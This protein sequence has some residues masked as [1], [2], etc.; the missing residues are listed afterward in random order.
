MNTTAI[1][2]ITS[3]LHDKVSVEGLSDAFLK[4]L[5]PDGGFEFRGADFSDFGTCPLNLIYI[6]TGGAEGIFQ[7]L[8]PGILKAGTGK[9]YLLTSGKNNS[10]AASLEI[11][12]YLQQQGL[13][14]EV[15]HGNVNALRE[16]IA[17]LEAVARAKAAL[18]GARVALVGRPSDWLIASEADREAI[19]ARLGMDFLDIPI[20]ALVAAVKALPPEAEN[21]ADL[22]E[23]VRPYFP[24]A[25]QIYRALKRM[26]GENR[27][28]ALT[29]RCFDLLT[30]LGNTGCI[31]LAKLNAE[32]TPA[33]CEGDVPAL[34]SMMI[35]RAL[36]GCTGFQANPARID[37]ESGEVLFAHC[38][39]SLDIPSAIC[40]DTHF[41]SGIGVGIHGEWPEGP[42]T[43]FKLSGDLSRCF[44]AE[45]EFLRN[46]YQDKLCRTQI[47]VR[48]SP[49]DARYFLTRPIGNHHIILPGRHK[50]LLS[51]FMGIDTI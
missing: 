14:G 47:V 35:A 42:V 16:R 50:A 21:S 41:E 38:T 28:D 11:L 10:L 29:L 26:I 8:L 45:G 6:R 19:K 33:S 43:V 48:L 1:Y 15:L 49:D 22:P 17:R 23:K 24:G 44:I 7:T 30:S 32:G 39:I 2:T 3:G 9:I 34:I 25:M 46:Q 51:E 12:S 31:G 37:T 40:Y 4:E 13:P 18:S 36:T 27:I 5:F 20:E